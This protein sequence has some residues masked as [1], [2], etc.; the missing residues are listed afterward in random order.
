MIA[1]KPANDPKR[2]VAE[3]E[4][5]D[6]L[7]ERVTN[8]SCHLTYLRDRV[9]SKQ[10]LLRYYAMLSSTDF[11]D[12]DA[13]N[14]ASASWTCIL[15]SGSGLLLGYYKPKASLI[16]EPCPLCKET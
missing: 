8:I 3:E 9:G 13:C 5:G 15:C 11:A 7:R 1:M 2:K 4:K 6:L 12:A 14:V 10:E 16:M